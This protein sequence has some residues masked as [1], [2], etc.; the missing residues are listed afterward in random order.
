VDVKVSIDGQPTSGVLLIEV[1]AEDTDRI[2]IQLL[3]AN[4]DPFVAEKI[5]YGDLY[6]RKGGKVLHIC[7]IHI[8]FDFALTTTMPL[9]GSDVVTGG[10]VA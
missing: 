1:S 4:P 6:G 7:D 3:S 10:Q 5:V 9:D 2:Q 8:P